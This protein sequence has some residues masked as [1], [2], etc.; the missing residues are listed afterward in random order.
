MDTYGVDLA[1]L[2]RS[3]QQHDLENHFDILALHKMDRLKHYGLHFSK[4]VGRLARGQ[5]ETKTVSQTLVDTMLVSLSAA[6]ALNQ[7]LWQVGPESAGRNDYDLLAFADAAGRF[8]DACEKVDHLEEFR[9]IALDANA[10]ILRY[11][12]HTAA[13][14]GLDLE[15]AIADRR[16]QLYSRQA[17]HGGK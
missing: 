7:R 1:A 4:Y 12:A 13:T 10:D 16:S 15:A 8:A 3:Q 14:L 6:N 9:S 2:Q 5:S 17:Y 11:V